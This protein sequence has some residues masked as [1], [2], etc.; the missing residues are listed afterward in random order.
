M[1]LHYLLTGYILSKILG[2]I[3]LCLSHFDTKGV[4][5]FMTICLPA[6]PES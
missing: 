5:V 6:Y 1:G 3:R 2:A 4:I